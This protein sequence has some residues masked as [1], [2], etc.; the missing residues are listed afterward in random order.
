VEKVCARGQH[1]QASVVA[2][3]VDPQDALGVLD[4]PITRDEY[5]RAVALADRYGL[6]RRD[7]PRRVGPSSA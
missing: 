2:Q 7:R 3:D 1:R 4:R 5:E 6:H